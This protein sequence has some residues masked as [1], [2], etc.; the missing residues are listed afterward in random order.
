MSGL[1]E[2]L[3]AAHRMLSRE[4]RRESRKQHPN[5]ARIARLRAER[6]AIKEHV[7]RHAP[8]QPR[9]VTFFRT[10]LFR[11]LRPGKQDRRSGEKEHP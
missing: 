3:L 10:I 6:R 4:V 8:R 1:I 9:A 5:A 7:G 11:L 2:R